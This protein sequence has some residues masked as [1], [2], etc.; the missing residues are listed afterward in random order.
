MSPVVPLSSR[1]TEW[2]TKSVPRV[3]AKAPATVGVSGRKLEAWAVIP[4][5][6][7]TTSRWPSSHTMGRGQ[8]PGVGRTFGG[9]WSP[10]ST[11]STSPVR[12]MKVVR[13]WFP[14]TR[15]PFSAR[16]SLEMAWEEK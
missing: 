14:F 8:S 9:R 4:A 5:G 1:F 11:V 2:N 15:M 12:R 3:Q 13:A 6:L 7:F 16:F 10:V